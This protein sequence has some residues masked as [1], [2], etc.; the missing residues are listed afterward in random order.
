MGENN[1]NF[2]FSLK[3]LKNTPLKAQWFHRSVKNVLERKT[4][5]LIFVPHM[6]WYVSIGRYKLIMIWK[7]IKVFCLSI[8]LRPKLLFVSL[9]K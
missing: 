4:P 5:S 9:N 3:G 7:N 8:N 6:S 2:P 1:R